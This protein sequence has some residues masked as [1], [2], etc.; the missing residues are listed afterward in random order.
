MNKNIRQMPNLFGVNGILKMGGVFVIKFL[1]EW[2][3][4][5]NAEQ[6]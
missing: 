4:V 3:I 2:R 5:V 6:L 1:R